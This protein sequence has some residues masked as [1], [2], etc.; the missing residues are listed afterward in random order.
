MLDR[1]VTTVIDAA[2]CTGCG[3]C[4]EVCPSRTLSLQEDKAAVTGDRCL[5]C[6][7]CAA[8]CPTGAIGVGAIDAEASRYA[9]FAADSRPL[10]GGEFATAPLVRLMAT[11]RSCRRFQ[12]RAVA[13]ALLEDLVKVGVTAPSG[14]NSQMWTFTLLS[15]RKSVLA[16]GDQVA[17]FFR[18]VNAMAEN[19]LLRN[20][21]RL[22][23]QRDLHTYFRDYRQSVSEALDEYEKMGRDRLFHGATAAIVVGSMPGGSTNAEDA[24]LAT[25]NILLAAHSMGLGSCLI[26][27]V[28]AA[29]QKD[30]R[31]KRFLEIPDRERVHA[32]IAMGYPDERYLRQAGRKRYVLRHVE[33]ERT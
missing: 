30:I 21:L 15:T 8:C 2:R 7:H 22:I 10:S 28:V 24:L 17:R 18:R 32:V 5:G 11:R 29:L 31:V 1:H 4:V 16:L 33:A 12:E 20:G 23:G 27:F 13:R 9:T 25:Q 6:D 14:T 26:G 3:I 19:S